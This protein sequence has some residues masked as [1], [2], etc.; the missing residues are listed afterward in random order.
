[1]FLFFHQSGSEANQSNRSCISLM[2]PG[3]GNVLL[4]PLPIC[5]RTSSTNTSLCNSSWGLSARETCSVGES[6]S[7]LDA[8]VSR[9]AK[10]YLCLSAMVLCS[11]GAALTPQSPL[12]LPGTLTGFLLWM[13][14]KT[15]NIHFIFCPVWTTQKNLLWP[16]LW[17]KFSCQRLF[18]FLCFSRVWKDFCGVIMLG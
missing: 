14:L 11:L 7:T 2:T 4:L 13:C 12:S 16:V 17:F 15:F 18:Y 3:P 9:G 10:D 5:F 1:M 6:P 8:G